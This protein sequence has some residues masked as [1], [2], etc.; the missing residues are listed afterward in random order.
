M[1]FCS[2]DTAGIYQA[3]LDRFT[4]NVCR[5]AKLDAAFPLGKAALRGCRQ[6]TIFVKTVSGQPFSLQMS[7]L[8][9][10]LSV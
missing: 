10:F 9:A 6:K 5:R 7:K 4:N 8:R 3:G 1:A 2:R